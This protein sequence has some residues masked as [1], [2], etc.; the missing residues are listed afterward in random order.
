[1]C[2][3]QIFP[4]LIIAR[5]SVSLHSFWSTYISVLLFGACLCSVCAFLHGLIYSALVRSHPRKKMCDG[6]LGSI[7]VLQDAHNA[8][9]CLS[10]E[11]KNGLKE[12]KEKI[13][14]VDIA[15]LD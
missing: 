15:A 13:S 8:S 7:H 6:L 2:G 3:D 9:M 14:F 4:Y 1:M 10:G 5:V 11:K 12:S